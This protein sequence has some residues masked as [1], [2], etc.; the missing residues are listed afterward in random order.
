MPY[1]MN[2]V[3]ETPEFHRVWLATE[4]DEYVALDIAFPKT[5]HDPSQP[6]YLVF[7]GLNGGSAEGYVVDLT[8]SRMRQGSTVVVL[9][10]RGL[11]DTPIHGWTVRRLFCYVLHDCSC[12]FLLTATY[13]NVIDFIRKFF[14]G[15][16]T[17]DAHSAASTLRERV[18]EQNQTLA[19]VGYSLG[20]IVLNHYVA[21]Y[22]D[23]VALDVSVS[24]SGALYCIPQKDFVRSQ[25]TWQAMIAAHAK[26]FFMVGKW[27]RRLHHQLGKKNYERLLRATNVVVRTDLLFATAGCNLS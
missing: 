18:L 14:H 24:I 26:D 27:G 15:V 19:G 12:S 1:M 11:M 4:D 22:Q 21:S 16:R 23:E 25:W 3:E 13:G 9:I 6:L 7:H 5:G 8:A 17:I 2:S 10:T 20:A